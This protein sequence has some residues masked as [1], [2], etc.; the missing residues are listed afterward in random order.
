MAKREALYEKILAWFKEQTATGVLKEGDV[1][2]SERELAAQFNVSRVPVR[3]AL[4]ILEFA[5]AIAKAPEGM[6]IQAAN[7]RW[8]QPQV[9]FSHQVTQETLKN[10]FEVRIFLESAA[11][12]YAA[13]RRTD[14]DIAEMRGTILEMLTAMNDSEQADNEEIIKASHRFHRCMIRA[15]KNPILEEIYGNLFE[16]LQYSKQHTLTVHRDLRSTVMDHEAI[17]SRIESGNAAEA[18]QYVRFHLERALER[19]RINS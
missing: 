4:H 1:I 5:G 16:L 15:A 6:K 9:S 11:A 2:P 8:V 13:Q 7:S 17:L 12:Q 3:E 14:E 18:G 19:L 10:L